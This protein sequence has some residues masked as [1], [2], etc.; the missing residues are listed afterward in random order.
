MVRTAQ[1][2][3]LVMSDLDDQLLWQEVT[4]IARAAMRDAAA[5]TAAAPPPVAVTSMSACVRISFRQRRRNA[6][7]LSR[8]ACSWRW[9]GVLDKEERKER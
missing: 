7:S 6:S 8:P 1:S 9:A 4:R 2:T 5:D 3:E